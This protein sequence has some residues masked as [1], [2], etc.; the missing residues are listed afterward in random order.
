LLGNHSVCINFVNRICIGL[1]QDVFY[2]NNALGEEFQERAPKDA[3][4]IHVRNYYA[5]NAK[6]FMRK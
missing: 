1:S 2:L 6:N 3:G 4:I 5:V